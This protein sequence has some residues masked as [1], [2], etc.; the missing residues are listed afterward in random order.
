MNYRRSMEVQIICFQ[1]LNNLIFDAIFLVQIQLRQKNYA[2]TN[3]LRHRVSLT[4]TNLTLKVP[5]T[6]IDALRHFETG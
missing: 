5:V 6:T 2:L 4:G 3:D 1:P